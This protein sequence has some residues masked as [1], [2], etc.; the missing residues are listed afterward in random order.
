V[1]SDEATARTA[2]EAAVAD[3]PALVAVDGSEVVRFMVVPLPGRPG[4]TT[5]RL[6]MTHHGA[7]PDDARLIYRRLYEAAAAKVVKLGCTYHSL[8]VPVEHGAAVDTF[9]ELEFG[10]DQIDGILRIPEHAGQTPSRDFVR[11]A[12][13]AD[14]D[15]I[16]E[17]AIELA[18]YHARSPMFQVAL[19]DVRSIRQGVEKSLREP[20]S[21]VVVETG[22][23]VVAMAQAEPDRAYHDAFDIG[24]NVV[25]ARHEDQAS[26]PRCSTTS[27]VGLRGGVHV[28]HRGVDVLQSRQRR[29]LQGERL[30]S[31]P[32]PPTSTDRH[33]S[34]VGGRTLRLHRFPAV[35]GRWLSEDPGG[36]ES[37]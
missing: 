14:V 36:A 37:R 22:G 33:Q 7:R 11:R 8:P 5:A 35:A 12:E 13:P 1:L 6:G 16:V 28:L 19:L 18:K 23:Q 30:H 32:V 34:G 3:G 10:V 24:M 2:V 4:T 26:V 21:A 17:L 15:S 29:V 20:R 31:D 27:S 25:T 9:F